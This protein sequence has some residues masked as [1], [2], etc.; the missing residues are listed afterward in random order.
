MD[1]AET[2]GTAE[3]EH[4][5]AQ[6]HNITDEPDE[7][8]NALEVAEAKY[9]KDHPEEAATPGTVIFCIML[10]MQ[11][12]VVFSLR[13]THTFM[14]ALLT[15]VPTCVCAWPVMSNLWRLFAAAIQ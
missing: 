9:A 10:V 6:A 7:I 2:E 13:I 14:S 3:A 15:Y 8:V 1:D 4:A 5:A 12:S 11:L